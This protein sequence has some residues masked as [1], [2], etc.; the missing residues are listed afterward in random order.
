M[1]WEPMNTA[2]KG[3]QGIMRNE[4]SYVRP[5]KILLLF[6]DDVISVGCWDWYYAENGSG[7]DGGEAWIEPMSGERLDL[8]YD[9][10]IN[11]A[12]LSSDP[13]SACS[14]MYARVLQLESALNKIIDGH[15]QSTVNREGM[16]EAEILLNRTPL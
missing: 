7:Y 1:S 15:H 14:Q 12:T 5:P 9:P 3:T 11:W 8:H 6:R 2:P 16:R 4:D 13:C 10:P